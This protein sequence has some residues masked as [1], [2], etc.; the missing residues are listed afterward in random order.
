MSKS[1]GTLTLD[2]LVNLTGFK[3]GMKDAENQAQS[4]SKQMVQSL[5]SVG[6]ASRDL[7]DNIGRLMS[8][9]S[10]LSTAF[11]VPTL[12]QSADAYT[13]LNNK[14]NLVVK[15]EKELQ[16]ALDDTFKIAQETS[17]TWSSVNEIYTKFAQNSDKLHL[18]QKQV[19]DITQTV[20]KAVGM[21][22]ASASSAD[23][24]LMQFGQA[25]NTGVLRGAELNSVMSQ[26]PALAK[27]LAD[28][29]GVAVG[30]LKTLGEEG[31]ITTEVMIEALQRVAPQ[32]ETEY[33]K[34]AT[35][36]SESFNRIQ[37]Q[38]TKMVGETDK[39]FGVSDKIVSVI[40]T[41]SAEMDKFVL[42][43]GGIATIMAG[44]YTSS[45]VQATQAT[46][47]KVQATRQEQLANVENLGILALEEKRK[48]AVAAM[49]I[50]QAQIAKMTA[51]TTE[52]QRIATD[53]LR[54]AQ[55]EYELQLR[56]STQ[57][58]NAYMM[59]QKQ[60]T[61]STSL[62]SASKN[63][64][65]GLVGG[66]VGLAVTIATLAGGYLLFRDN[67]K[68]ATIELDL[69]GKTV[70]QLV[71][72]YHKLEQHQKRQVMRDLTEQI[73]KSREEHKLAVIDLSVYIDHLSEVGLV[74]SKTAQE[75]VRINEQYRKGKIDLQ[76]LGSQLNQVTGLEDE[77]K[78]KIDE[79]IARLS[80]AKQELQLKNDVL[81]GYNT[82]AQQATDKSQTFNNALS[83]TA[84]RAKEAK[85]QLESLNN[86]AKNYLNS[87]NSAQK[88]AYV[89]TNMQYG[90]SQDKASFMFEA[91][92]KLGIP[93][94]ERLSDEIK[95]KLEKEYESAQKLSQMAS[96]SR[97]ATPKVNQ[98]KKQQE[99][100]QNLGNGFV[101]NSQLQGLKIKSREAISGGQVRGYTAEFAQLSQSILGDR[102]KYFSAFNDLYHKGRNS[103]HNRGMAFD[104]VLKDAK[105]A[106]QAVA[107]LQQYAKQYGYVVKILD[108]YS[109]PSKHSTGGHL[110]V[111]IKG[112]QNAN[113]N[114]DNIQNDLKLYDDI[115]KQRQRILDEQL[116]LRQEISN[117]Y[118]D[119][120]QKIIWAESEALKELGQAGFNTAD[121]EKY[122]TLI[123]QRYA[124]EQ[125]EYLKRLKL[126][127]NQYQWNEQQKLEYSYQM[128]RELIENDIRLSDMVK[129]EKLK[130]LEKQYQYE[131]TQMELNQRKRFAEVS[132][133]LHD[134]K[135]LVRQ[136]YE[137]EREEIALTIDARERS[138]LTAISKAQERD[139]LI[140]QQLQANMDY[141]KIQAEMNGQQYDDPLKMSRFQRTQA[142]DALYQSNVDL[143]RHREQGGLE[144]LQVLRE[145]QLISEQEFERQKTEIMRQGLL[146]REN[147]YLEFS[148]H[149][150]D[151]E[152][153]Y[154]RES[155]QANLTYA[156]QIH[157]AMMGLASN[158]LGENSKAYKTMFAMQKAMAIANAVLAMK[159]N[160]AEAMKIGF[161]QNIP[162]IAAA[163]T[164]GLA[165]V[166]DV[167]SVMMPNGMAHSGIDNIPQEGTWLLD[168][169]ERVL[170]PRQ[171]ADLTQFLQ[172]QN[173]AE[174]GQN[175][176]VNVVVNSDN[177]SN[178][179]SNEQFGQA[180][181]EAI[182]AAVLK[183]IQQEKRQ[184]GMLA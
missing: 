178:V 147:A 85:S 171:N 89:Q 57:A 167:R 174:S 90:W 39:A 161:P 16:T 157:G 24:A 112:R 97:Q 18:S 20:A 27:A 54:V 22:G 33:A 160:I 98:V 55:M 5:D 119:D 113:M 28:G 21:S 175:I 72:E 166:N 155:V 94:H 133:F 126:E 8:I 7:G 148:S 109:K 165:I 129:Q 116:K 73:K 152:S 66:P 43:A 77:H 102:L 177:S 104:I 136:R 64:L 79:K 38:F 140:N 146:E 36:I 68:K 123:Q 34:T 52:A 82:T 124:Y 163:T 164:Q 138:R 80:T 14:L 83:D 173:R 88:L 172:N 46:L 159:Q 45:M 3:R 63:T 158:M 31:K 107:E 150:K 25:L 176:V 13:Q 32:V 15:S 110:H 162:M 125:A 53:K 23:A 84:N 81:N 9:S 122:K 17:A 130:A 120:Y 86:E 144:Q 40:S 78:R 108:E 48:T 76:E 137:M 44:R 37:N 42:V 132:R 179:E 6:K 153:A 170:S 156:Q 49:E 2:M 128:D 151:I 99:R 65:L 180:M 92:K 145:Q 183:I 181:G 149:L 135:Q 115:E 41:I 182:K 19:A 4:S 103:D 169:G 101:N 134:E 87:L 35:S 100:L 106:K 67:A 50:R 168:K 62:M 93:D 121:Y 69:Q 51:I 10:G 131:S 59:A 111:S 30:D 154:F 142:L 127:L 96:V 117:Q 12:I 11:S 184:G 114:F 118:V 56:S 29:M 61:L 70:A 26:T 60:A 1:L 47:A 91:R 71:E 75:V 95:A 74:S 105:Q 58:T 143:S 139:D 141:E